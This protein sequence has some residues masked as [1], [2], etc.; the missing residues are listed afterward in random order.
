MNFIHFSLPLVFAFAA[1][2]I[3]SFPCNQFGGQAPEKDGEEM[4]C[5]LLKSNTKLGDLF[6]KIDVNGPNTNPLFKYLKQ[7][8][9]GDD[10]K[11][12]FAKFLVNKSGQP[13]ERFAPTTSPKSI[14]SKIDELLK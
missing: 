1:F 7:K 6:R 12:N 3:L 9:G 10:I 8:L 13:V 2:K 5:H 14:T 4:V 11:W